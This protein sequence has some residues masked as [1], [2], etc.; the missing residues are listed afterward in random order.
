MLLERM[1]VLLLIFPPALLLIYLGGWY[2]TIATAWVLALA[3][4]EYANIFRHGG[5]QPSRFLLI[6]FVILLSIWRGA[7]GMLANDAWLGVIVVIS[8]G[9]H[10]FA[11]EAGHERA[12]SD[13]AI[14]TTGILYLGWLGPYMISLRAIQPDGLWWLFVTFF[15][16]W[17]ADGFAYLVGR[18]IGRHQ[19]SPRVSPKKSWEGY[20]A[21]VFFGTLT[22]LLAGALFVQV[23]PAITPLRGLGLGFCPRPAG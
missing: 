16:I 7:F 15:P 13:F 9:W 4:W 2:L 6:G 21:G 18:K 8:L 11:Y 3:A 14:T 10:V 17:V 5:Y 12:A 1:K 22:G 20:L 19:M 23:N